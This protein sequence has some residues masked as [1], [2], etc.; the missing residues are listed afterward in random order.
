MKKWLFL[1]AA[2]AA[3]SL[4]WAAGGMKIEVQIQGGQDRMAYL[5]YYYGDKQFLQ[6]SLVLYSRGKGTF[7]APEP[8]PAGIY[9]LALKNKGYFDLLLSDDQAFALS[10]DT[11]DWAGSLK[12]A[13]SRQNELFFDFQAFTRSN[14][15][16]QSELMAELET[17]QDAQEQARL[18]A[19]LDQ[20]N[21]RLEAEWRRVVAEN[22]GTFFA[23]LLE[24]MNGYTEE[25]R[26]FAHMD[27]GH[28]GLLRTP[29]I[30]KACQMVLARNLNNYRPNELLI[31]ELDSLIAKARPNPEAYQFVTTH[32]LNFFNTFQRLGMN[33]VFVHLADNY[34]LGGKADWFT[35]EA[36]E[37]LAARTQE[38]RASMVGQV[39]KPFEME[40]TTGEFVALDELPHHYVLL[41]F[42]KTGCGHCETA[43]EL[44]SEFYQEA[45]A[46]DADLELVAIYTYQNRDDWNK[47]IQ[48]YGDPDWINV[49]DPEDKNNYHLNY[50]IVSTPIVYLLDQDRKIVA[51][52]AG[53]DAIKALLDDLRAWMR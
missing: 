20:V 29:L 42:W 39:A 46:A 21:A 34:F 8:L 48:E 14:Q 10:A 16:R 19:E 35:P 52:R 45:R 38:L 49:W 51:K 36:T 22:P 30:H 12:A 26:F 11:A 5:G 27:F 31:A 3:N 15:P 1:T 13:R 50:Y 47:A 32:F 4:A 6:D 33:E 43:S 18:R 7:A 24:A 2:V 44:L 17:A 23:V 37:Q 53:E 28:P 41:F 25:D 40:R 9:F